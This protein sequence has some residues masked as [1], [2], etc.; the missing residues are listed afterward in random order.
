MEIQLFTTG[1]KPQ[2]AHGNTILQLFTTTTGKEPP[3]LKLSTLMF[4]EIQLFTMGRK[5]HGLKLSTL[6]FMEIQLLTTTTGQ[7]PHGL[8]LSTLMSMARKP[9][10]LSY[11]P[12]L[13]LAETLCHLCVPHTP[14]QC[15]SQSVLFSCSLPPAWFD[16]ISPAG[17]RFRPSRAF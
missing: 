4:M 1:Q 13:P 8:K 7:K 14:S 10:G 9:H 17:V 11:I 15:N 6:M 12:G 16:L 3:G 5:P 2:G